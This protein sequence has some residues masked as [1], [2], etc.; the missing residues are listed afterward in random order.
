[1]LC[2]RPQAAAVVAARR[3]P[4]LVVR[5]AAGKVKLRLIGQTVE[6]RDDVPRTR[7][8]C[9]DLSGGKSCPHIK[10][11][12]HLWLVAGIDRAGRRDP[13]WRP[14]TSELRVDLLMSWPVPPSCGHDVLEAAVREG[15]S[16][17]RMARAVGLRLSGLRYVISKAIAKLQLAADG[18]DI[19]ELLA[20]DAPDRAS[21]G[22]RGTHAGDE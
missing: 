11:S 3:P 10:C 21:W 18:T 9:P 17:P 12:W 5:R 22:E 8:E 13:R 7:A 16:V 4:D 19:R 14:S 1:M 15:W 2:A 6:L 20:G